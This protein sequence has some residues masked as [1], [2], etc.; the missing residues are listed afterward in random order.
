MDFIIEQQCKSQES[1]SINIHDANSLVFSDNRNSKINCDT[2]DFG[3]TQT[4]SQFG[5]E[6]DFEGPFKQHRDL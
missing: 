3:P 4:M 2:Q 5:F 6:C 1:F